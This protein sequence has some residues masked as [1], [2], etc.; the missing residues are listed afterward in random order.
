MLFLFNNKL[1][2]CGERKSNSKNEARGKASRERETKIS[3]L[4][5]ISSF[6]DQ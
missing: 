4:D 1:A 2:G 3:G 6:F 5:F